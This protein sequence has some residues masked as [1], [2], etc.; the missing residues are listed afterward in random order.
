MRLHGPLAFALLLAGIATHTAYMAVDQRDAERLFYVARGIEGVMLCVT[1]AYFAFRPTVRRVPTGV[2]LLACAFIAY[3][4]ALT[5]ACGLPLLLRGEYLRFPLV[6]PLDGLCGVVTGLP[7]A[8]GD[9]AGFLVALGY[10]MAIRYGREPD[11]D[12]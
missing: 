4:E 2:L 11:H 7:W 3:Q 12:D 5:A 9:L 8:L 10:F 6:G 1:L